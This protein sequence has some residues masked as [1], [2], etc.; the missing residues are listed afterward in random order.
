MNVMGRRFV[1]VWTMVSAAL[2][3]AALCGFAAAQVPR[4]EMQAT[5]YGPEDRALHGQFTG[6]VTFPIYVSDVQRSASFY[7]DVLGFRFL[8]Y[9]DHDRRRY[10]ETWT[11]SIPPIYAGFEAG[12]LTFGLHKPMNEEQERFIGAGR[13]YFRV[14]DLEQHRRRIRAWGGR[15]SEISSSTLLTRF[16]VADPDGLRIYFAVTAENAAIDPW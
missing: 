14:K 10:V 9:Y 5:P 2:A 16:F 6:E 1:T 12:G 7:R 4:G 11:D 8:G 3:A 15:P 13:Y